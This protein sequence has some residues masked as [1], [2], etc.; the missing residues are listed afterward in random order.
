[1]GWTLLQLKPKPMYLRL[2]PEAQASTG[3]RVRQPSTVS[4]NT[5]SRN[6][7]GAVHDAALRGR[8]A[9]NDMRTSAAANEALLLHA[10][11]RSTL[12]SAGRAVSNYDGSWK[13]YLQV[14]VLEINA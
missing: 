13:L 12:A 6:S 11:Q 9:M 4:L 7:G 1:M 5:H 2:K 14:G 3:E 10:C 8:P